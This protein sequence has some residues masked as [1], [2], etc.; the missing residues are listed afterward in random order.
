MI[1]PLFVWVFIGKKKR[2]GRINKEEKYYNK[3]HISFAKN[4]KDEIPN[5]DVCE[6][7]KIYKTF[8]NAAN[9]SETI[10]MP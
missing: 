7:Q 8:L 9:H 10:L 5:N 3:K 1:F 6:L 4:E 2:V